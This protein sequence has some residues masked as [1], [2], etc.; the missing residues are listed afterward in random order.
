MWP[1]S[2]RLLTCTTLPCIC[3]HSHEVTVT[4]I[5]E[6]PGI[7]LLQ[8][9][10]LKCQMSPKARPNQGLVVCPFHL[11]T[12]MLRASIPLQA[13]YEYSKPFL[14]W[15]LRT[16]VEEYL[17]HG[18]NANTTGGVWSVLFCILEASLL[19]HL[20]IPRQ[21]GKRKQMSNCFL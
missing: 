7:P 9:I 8:V 11:T 21:Q 2:S 18:E 5:K 17:H 14:S 6:A 4:P 15:L 12:A 10:Q 20:F 1:L 19:A 13:D 16:T 3:H